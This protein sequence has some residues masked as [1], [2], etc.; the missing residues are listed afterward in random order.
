[1]GMSNISL[2]DVLFSKVQQRVLSI[3]F[4]QPDRAFFG[5]EII[6]LAGVGTGAVIRELDKLV[7][8]GLVSVTRIGNQKHYQS[9]HSSPIFSE[10]RGIVLKTFGVSDVLRQ[11]LSPFA[12]RIQV[13]FIYGSVAKG[14]DTAKSDIDL[15]VVSDEVGY[16]DLFAALSDAEKAVGRQISPTIYTNADWKK[17]LTEGNDFI[18]RIL[19]QPKIFMLGT[20]NDIRQSG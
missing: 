14:Q 7:S 16:S 15:M 9:N 2:S 5:N 18:A 3:I 11:A 12:E 4:G 20:E 8:S 19:E 10:L 6:R 17:R 1:M 13:A